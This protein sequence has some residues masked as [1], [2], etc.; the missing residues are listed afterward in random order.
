[1]KDE[2]EFLSIIV[3]VAAPPCSV[4]PPVIRELEQW[5]LNAVHIVLRSFDPNSTFASARE[6]QQ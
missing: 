2:Y 5:S 1:M 6:I 3:G 4:H